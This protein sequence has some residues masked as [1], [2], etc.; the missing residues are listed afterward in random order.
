MRWF[1]RKRSLWFEIVWRYDYVPQ[2]AT[3]V[4]SPKGWDKGVKRN[5]AEWII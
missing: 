5:P 1:S 2:Y 4:M 3:M